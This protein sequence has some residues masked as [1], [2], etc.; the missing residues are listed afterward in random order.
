MSI[1]VDKSRSCCDVKWRVGFHPDRKMEGHAPSWP[2]M[3]GRRGGRPSSSAISYEKLNG[4]TISGHGADPRL[5]EGDFLFGELVF[6]VE[7]KATNGRGGGI[8]T[9]DL[10]LPKLP[11]YQAALR[12]EI[13]P[14]DSLP[15]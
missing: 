10:Q 5:D 12:P 11:R 3:G 14:F 9:P 2:L 4:F 7:Q 6:G 8:R 1:N 13:S 15:L